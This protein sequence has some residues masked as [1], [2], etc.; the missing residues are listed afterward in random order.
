MRI[1]NLRLYSY[2]LRTFRNGA[3]MV[4]DYRAGRPCEQAIL[5][6]GT[7]LRHPPGRG[8]FIGTILEIWVE[9]CYTADGFY[10][11]GPNDIVLDVGAHV[12][13]FSLWLARRAPTIRVVAVEPSPDNFSCLQANLRA[14]EAFGVQA[15]AGALG[16]PDKDAPSNKGRIEPATDR[17]ID[18]RLVA[19][20]DDDPDAVPILSLTDLV[21]D[22][23]RAR[24]S[25][26]KMD[27]EGAEYDAIEATPD[28]ILERLDR[29]AMEYHDHIRP[30][31][32]AMLH[33]RFGPTHQIAVYPTEDRGYGVF[34][35]SRRPR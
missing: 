19:A 32:L 15:I 29:V 5:W 20:D 6:D 35:A 10:E 14:F 11:P 34:L 8:G 31:T 33:R 16:A 23:R 28:H 25:L 22:T 18:H 2:L 3:S 17:S 12:G 30:G 9:E 7:R 4:R 27:I 26:L 1:R 13:L 21:D 24:I